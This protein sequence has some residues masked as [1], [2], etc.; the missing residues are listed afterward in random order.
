MDGIRVD[1][2]TTW[3]PPDEEAVVDYIVSNELTSTGGVEDLDQSTV[4]PDTRLHDHD[5]LLLPPVAPHE[6]HAFAEADQVQ[7]LLDVDTYQGTQW[8]CADASMLLPYWP[9]LDLATDSDNDGVIEPQKHGDDDRIEAG[10]PG[11]IVTVYDGDIPPELEELAE[12][13]VSFSPNGYDEFAP[14]TELVLSWAGYAELVN[15]WV[16]DEPGTPPYV[17]PSTSYTWAG[18]AIES[19]IDKSFYV[20]AL[21]PGNVEFTLTFNDFASGQPVPD[22]VKMSVVQMD[23]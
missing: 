2:Y 9:E 21:A 16:P 5:W 22:K 14:G 11:R 19:D 7:V 8:A 13:R 1:A 15:I 17:I 4:E 10:S 12:L 20:Q 23:L 6:F 18:N 3:V